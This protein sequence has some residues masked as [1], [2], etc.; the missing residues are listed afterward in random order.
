M[1]NLSEVARATLIEVLQAAVFEESERTVDIEGPFG[2]PDT[3]A[4]SLSRTFHTLRGVRA[5]LCA[6]VDG[7]NGGIGR[8]G[9]NYVPTA[10]CQTL[11]EEFT[12]AHGITSYFYAGWVPRS[13]ELRNGGAPVVQ[14][15]SKFTENS[16]HYIND[17]RPSLWIV[18]ESEVRPFV[19]RMDVAFTS[20]GWRVE[21]D[22]K[23]EHS[24]LFNQGAGW[25][26]VV[27]DLV[28]CSAALCVRTEKGLSMVSSEGYIQGRGGLRSIQYELETLRIAGKQY[29]STTFEDGEYDNEEDFESDVEALDQ[30]LRVDYLRQR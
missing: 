20:R 15:D 12:D 25:G 24:L 18:Y 23:H 22:Y 9:F 27:R 30:L 3:L 11:I 16:G 17:P 1:T 2:H 13:D 8:I 7:R 28:Q 21:T 10:E 4:Y 19:K 14:P 26:L 5:G 29:P 6:I